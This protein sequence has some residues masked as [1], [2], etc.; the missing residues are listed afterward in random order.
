[1]SGDS[2]FWP[3]LVNAIAAAMTTES[4]ESF[5]SFMVVIVAMEVGYLAVN[6]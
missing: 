1:V 5:W 6:L 3:Q 4:N 2:F